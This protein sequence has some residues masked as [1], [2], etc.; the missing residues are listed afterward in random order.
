MR[1]GRKQPMLATGAKGMNVKL[2]RDGNQS[3]TV[4]VVGG[5]TTPTGLNDCTEMGTFET[6]PV[7][8]STYSQMPPK[9][10]SLFLADIKESSCGYCSQELNE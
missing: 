2:R 1:R 6:M 7:P 10:V 4:G 9:E 8:Y 3:M 5:S